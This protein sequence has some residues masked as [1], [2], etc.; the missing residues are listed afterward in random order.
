MFIIRASSFVCYLKDTLT[1]SLDGWESLGGGKMRKPGIMVSLDCR[2][3]N[4]ET[5]D[6]RNVLVHFVLCGNTNVFA[7]CADKRFNYLPF[8][9][10]ENTSNHDSCWRTDGVDSYLTGLYFKWAD[11]IRQGRAPRELHSGCDI[12]LGCHR[13]VDVTYGC[14]E[15]RNKEYGSDYWNK[16]LDVTER[17]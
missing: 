14:D 2:L 9:E 1:D 13:L 12:G 7:Y 8:E 4:Y 5:N 10:F 11:E 3:S 6:R 17:K 16:L 15:A